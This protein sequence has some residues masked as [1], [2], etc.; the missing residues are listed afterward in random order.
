MRFD[1]KAFTASFTI[2]TAG[3][4]F[5]LFVWCSANGFGAQIVQIF[6]SIHPSGGFSIIENIGSSFFMKVPGI[7]I[8]TVYAVLDAFIFSFL[9]SSLNNLIVTKSKKK[10]S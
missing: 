9:L 7:F 6:E 4:L 5:L 8:N 10:K 3:F 2:I 1:V